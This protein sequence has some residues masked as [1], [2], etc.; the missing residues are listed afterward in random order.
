MKISF[1]NERV[2]CCFRSQES[3]LFDVILDQKSRSIESS[4]RYQLELM[5]TILRPNKEKQNIDQ[6]ESMREFSFSLLD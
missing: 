4:N 5:R 2:H 1:V 6:I 3:I